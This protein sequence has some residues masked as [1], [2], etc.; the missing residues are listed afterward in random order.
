MLK[1]FRILRFKS[2]DDA[3]LPLAPLTLLVGANASGK[4]N[5]LEAIRMLVLLARGQRL[6]GLDQAVQGTEFAVRGRLQDLVAGAGDSFELQCEITE[7]GEYDRLILEIGV[8]DEGLRIRNETIKRN[9]GGFGLYWVEQPAQHL[10]HDLR[11]AYDNFSRGGVKPK[12]AASDQMAIFL[13]FET[14][15]RFGSDHKKSQALIPKI[16]GAYRKA[17]TDV[18]FLDPQPSR[19][20]G[21]SFQNDSILQADGSNLSAVVHGLCSEADKKDQLLSLIRSLPEQEIR[22]IK[23]IHTPRNEVMLQLVETFGGRSREVDAPLLSDG[24][25]R[26]MAVA[27]SLI[28]APKGA[29]VIIEEIDNG[30]HPSRAKR[31]L[32][33]IERIATAR[34]LKVLLTTHNPALMDALPRNA[35]QDAVFCYRHP[36]TGM[37]QLARLSDLGDYPSLIAQG[38]LGSLITSGTVDKFVKKQI[39][40]GE[41]VREQ[42]DWLHGL[43]EGAN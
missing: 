19:M 21:Y 36:D 28:V 3:T 40:R 39:K 25:L 42:L 10:S 15:A 24:T 17:L 1:S 12:V 26:I 5:A 9:D 8:G 6:S 16:C 43:S 4:S 7:V 31:L 13:Q 27:T 2:Y 18:V 35:I 23:F 22:D 38:A 29:L 20:R 41:G 11:V 32:T 14:S 30:V 33:D 34:G 37:S